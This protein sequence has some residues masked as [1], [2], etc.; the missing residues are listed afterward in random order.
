MS[1][2]GNN[3]HDPVSS[4]SNI[5]IALRYDGKNAPKVTAKGQ[6]QLAERIIALAEEADVPIYPDAELAVVLS[7][8]PLGEEIPEELYRAIAEVISFAYLIAGKFPEGFQHDS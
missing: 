3:N 2:H 7:Q 4:D 6:H 8:I 5:A 1:K